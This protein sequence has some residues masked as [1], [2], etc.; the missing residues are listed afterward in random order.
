[1]LS[2]MLSDWFRSC[3]VPI[4]VLG[5][6]FACF[7]DF[8]THDLLTLLICLC[9]FLILFAHFRLDR[10]GKQIEAIDRCAA[11]RLSDMSAKLGLP[12]G[13]TDHDREELIRAH[14]LRATHPLD[15]ID[16]GSE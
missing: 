8:N 12:I 2:D 10:I 15:Y 1:M 11:R 13:D 3:A 16:S 5:V 14:N 4:A 7:G 9:A 6:G